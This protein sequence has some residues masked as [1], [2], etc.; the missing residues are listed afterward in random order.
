ML[1]MNNMWDMC[2]DLHSVV[3]YVCGMT[4]VSYPALLQCMLLI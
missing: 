3:G 4:V 2:G 1:L